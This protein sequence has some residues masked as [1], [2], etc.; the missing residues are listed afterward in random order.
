M[1]DEDKAVSPV[2]YSPMVGVGKALLRHI[3][4]DKPAWLASMPV[5]LAQL[6]YESGWGTSALAQKKNW[7]GMK[8]RKG[9]RLA[10]PFP[11]EDWAGETS[12]Y[13]M[14]LTAWD[15][16]RYYFVF[17]SGKRYRPATDR[18][19]DPHRF[20]LELA[21]AGYCTAIQGVKA[22]NVPKVYRDRIVELS[23]GPAFQ[24]LLKEVLAA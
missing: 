6:C 8:Y 15:F 2:D 18:R 5:I 3:L 16:V 23:R 17:I 4:Q 24:A 22:E 13:C 20:L 12:D 9:N 14:F 1:A 7:G 19:D 10:R 11:Y 21:K